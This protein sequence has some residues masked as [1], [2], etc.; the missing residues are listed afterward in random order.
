MVAVTPVGGETVFLLFVNVN[1][2]LCFPFSV[3]FV[4]KSMST[5]MV[6][7]PSVL[8]SALPVSFHAFEVVPALMIWVAL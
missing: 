6:S 7:L 3:A 5:T 2:V 8:V 4:T 1:V